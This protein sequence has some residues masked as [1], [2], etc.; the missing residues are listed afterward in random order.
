MEGV[1]MVDCLTS[2]ITQVVQMAVQQ[3]FRS[4]SR[5]LYF[6]TCTLIVMGH[7]HRCSYIVLRSDYRRY[8]RSYI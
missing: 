8:W 4:L 2:T 5:I 7:G 6:K 1:V 3:P